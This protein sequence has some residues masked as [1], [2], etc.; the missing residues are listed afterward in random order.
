MTEITWKYADPQLPPSQPVW[1]EDQ[2]HG[3]D[4][5]LGPRQ[6]PTLAC[7]ELNATSWD[8]QPRVWQNF[9]T[10]TLPIDQPNYDEC[11]RIVCDELAKWELSMPERNLVCGTPEHMLLWR[12]AYE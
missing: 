6:D 2:K 4:E 5:P 9:V 7:L 8:D 12:L 3:I 11:W 1:V 10:Q